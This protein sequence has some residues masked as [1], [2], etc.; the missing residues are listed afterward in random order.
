MDGRWRDGGAELGQ[1]AVDS[2]VAPQRVSLARRMAIRAILRTVGGR[3]GRRRVLVSYFRAAS[4]RCQASS[5]AG[6][7]G[8]TR[9]TAAAGS[10]GPAQRTRPG[11]PAR[12]A[13]RYS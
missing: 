3:R 13:M 11:R 4:L 1:L 8:K 7:T 9:P 2:P 12:T 6:V 10:T 5:V